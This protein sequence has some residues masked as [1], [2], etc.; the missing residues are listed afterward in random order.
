MSSL[1]EIVLSFMQEEAY[2]PLSAE[3][4][5]EELRLKGKDLAAFWQVL[6]ELEERAAIVKTRYDRYGLPEKMNL[7]V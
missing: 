6:E 1:E 7:V 4:L 2:R 3:E 5:A